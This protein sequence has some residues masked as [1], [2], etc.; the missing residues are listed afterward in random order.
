MLSIGSLLRFLSWLFYV[1]FIVIS[2]FAVDETRQL[3]ND[4]YHQ[5]GNVLYIPLLIC[6]PDNIEVDGESIAFDANEDSCRNM[7]YL[8]NACALSLIFSMAATFT[9]MVF[10]IL[11]FFNKGPF[12]KTK[13]VL[14]MGLFLIFILVQTAVCIWS[15]AS[16][17]QY[18]TNYF[19]EMIGDLGLDGV[20]TISTYGNFK[21]MYAA[22][23]FTLANSGL[24]LVTALIGLCCVK[25]TDDE[26]THTPEPK[27]PESSAQSVTSHVSSSSL[28]HWQMD[29]TPMTPPGAGANSMDWA[30]TP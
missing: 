23:V 20:K 19:T 16:E 18:W 4:Q 21:I 12:K 8:V 9:F 28:P 22:G 13:S 17:A 25:D 27:K 24:L 14:G 29:N 3:L 2:G 30:R 1:G 5:I 10:D 7:K 6:R 11:A 15:V 26:S